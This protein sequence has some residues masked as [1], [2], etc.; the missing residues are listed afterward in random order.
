[1]SEQSA[2]DVMAIL[3]DLQDQIDDLTAVVTAH[4][5]QLDQLRGQRRA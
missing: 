4:Q 1:M 3:A 5:Q 2:V